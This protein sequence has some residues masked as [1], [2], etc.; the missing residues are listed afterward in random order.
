MIIKNVSFA[1]DWNDCNFYDICLTVDKIP[2]VE[3]TCIRRFEDGK[4]LYYGEN[5]EGVVSFYSCGCE[6]GGHDANYHW[7]SRPGVFNAL[8]KKCMEVVFSDNNTSRVCGYMT[9]EAVEKLLVNT[10][11]AIKVRNEYCFNNEIHYSI[12]KI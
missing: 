8:G 11:Y 7:S 5:E 2:H 1:P 12:A 10:P 6:M 3:A 9:V 4:K